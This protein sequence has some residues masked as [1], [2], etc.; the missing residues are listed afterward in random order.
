MKKP[1]LAIGRLM[2]FATLPVTDRDH[3]VCGYVKK[4]APTSPHHTLLIP[5]EPSANHVI[6]PLDEA[7]RKFVHELAVKD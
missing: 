6:K 4:M 1:V 5:N 3:T 2:A 7:E